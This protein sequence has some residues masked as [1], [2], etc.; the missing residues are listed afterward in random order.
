MTNLLSNASKYSEEGDSIDVTANRR[1]PWYEISVRD[2]GLGIKEEDLEKIFNP[3]Y[4]A[5]ELKSQN[6]P[7]TG[8]GLV[9]AK[10]IIVR[11]GGSI[12][13]ESV[14][15]EGAVFK[16]R[17]PVLGTRDQESIGDDTTGDESEAA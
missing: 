6:V 12:S 8:L 16:I 13:V 9:I 2:Y 10:S 14:Y 15:G 5:D 1:G 17:L 3:F 4:R 11:H 7:G